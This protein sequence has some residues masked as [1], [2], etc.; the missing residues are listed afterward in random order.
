MSKSK[1]SH[2]RISGI[3]GV[4]PKNRINIDDEIEFYGN[5]PKRLARNK[6]I[7]GLGTRYT[8]GE[9]ETTCDLCE[10]AA[11]RLLD[12]MKVNRSSIDA[13]IAYTTT[14]DHLAPS[15]AHI[16]HGRLG[17]SESCSCFETNGGCTSTVHAMLLAFSMVESGAAKRVLLLGGDTPSNRNDVRNRQTAILLADSAVAT[18][19][20]YSEE[21]TLSWF[22]S[23]SRG[24]KWDTLVVPAGGARLPI[25]KDIMEIEEHNSLG[26]IWHPWD[27]IMKGMEVFKFTMEIGPALIKKML[28][29]SG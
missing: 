7:L 19:V 22:D 14:P 16:L 15:N 4:V 20:E 26:D 1:F 8:I 10:D 17:L 12:G 6:K 27:D 24:K 2:V 29:A 21:E 18:L 25:R 23:G 28:G 3:A 9:D 5:D 11:I 13:L